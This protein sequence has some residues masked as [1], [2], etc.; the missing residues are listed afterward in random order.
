M[1][2][3]GWLAEPTPEALEA[4]V[5]DLVPGL[6]GGTVEWGDSRVS[7]GRMG[8]RA[9]AVIDGRYMAK[10]ACSQRHAEGIHREG[11]VLQTLEE[12]GL[13]IAVPHVL[14]VGRDPALFVMSLVPGVPLTGDH[15]AVSSAD[16][17]R[18]VGRELGRHLA[19]LHHPDVARAIEDASLNTF[20]PRPQA[21]TDEIRLRFLALAPPTR[22]SLLLTWCDWTDEILADRAPRQSFVHGDLHGYNELWDLDTPRLLALVDLEESGLADPHFDFRY[23]PAQAASLALLDAALAS[24][25]EHSGWV[26][27]V[28]RVMAWHVRTVLG[29]ALWRTEAGVELPDGGTVESWVDGLSARFTALGIAFD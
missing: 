14:A 7:P 29:D 8:S 10:V 18:A 23:L 2:R 24:Y 3:V 12:V 26:P 25:A 19:A 27:D 20:E 16:G 6:G 21:E 4:A 1:D 9:T 17:Q 5:A 22:R 28:H 11:R 13:G 15:P